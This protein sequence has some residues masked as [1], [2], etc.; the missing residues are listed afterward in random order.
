MEHEMDCEQMIAKLRAEG[1][2]SRR[3][4]L[5]AKNEQAIREKELLNQVEHIRNEFN[6]C[7][8]SLKVAEERFSC[9]RQENSKLESKFEGVLDCFE[10][11]LEAF[12]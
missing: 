5:E 2:Q 6:Q 12:K 3:D 7:Q 4:F 11:L 1:E 10:R 8:R 9:Q